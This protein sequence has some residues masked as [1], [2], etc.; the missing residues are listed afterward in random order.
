MNHLEKYLILLFL[1]SFHQ[2]VQSFDS[3]NGELLHN[4]NCMRCH[5]PDVYI[6][7]NRM[8]KSFDELHERVRQCEIMA[9]MAWFD[10]EIDDVTAFLNEAYYKFDL[11]K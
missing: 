1:F 5:Q 10:E 4:E 9:E 7:E 6:R 2:S 8:I 3:A 11:E